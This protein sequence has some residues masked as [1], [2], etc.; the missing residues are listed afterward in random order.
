M[1]TSH[2][3]MLLRGLCFRQVRGLCF[4]QVRLTVPREQSKTLSPF[5]G[6]LRS[7]QSVCWRG[8]KYQGGTGIALRPF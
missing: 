5:A 8:Q 7:A 4:R 1:F 6:G 2:G 3:R